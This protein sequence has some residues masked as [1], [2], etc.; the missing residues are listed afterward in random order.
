MREKIIEHITSRFQ[1]YADL[2]EQVSDEELLDNLSVPRSKDLKNHFWCVVGARESYTRG[3]ASGEWGGF[4]CS[5]QKVDKADVI[6]GLEASA[7]AFQNTIAKIEDWT[8][9]RDELLTS[10]LE[11]EVM[12]E[13]QIIRH[14]Y[15]L[16]R[17]L[18]G[19]WKWA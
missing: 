12:H 11:H 16:E 18:P 3:L 6:A 13:G 4:K 8:E 9:A 1:S 17:S 7:E 19:S 10:L 5:L 15:A 14:T 2:A